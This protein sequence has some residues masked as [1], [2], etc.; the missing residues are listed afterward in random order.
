MTVGDIRL[1]H[2]TPADAELLLRWANDP[3]VRAASFESSPIE[4][5]THVRWLQDRL[6]EGTAFYIAIF[7]T[8]PVGYAR[9]ERR[10]GDSGEIAASVDAAWRGQGLGA[11]LIAAAAARA[12]VELRL[13]DIV[14]RV[15]TDNA[16]SVGAFRSAGF[17]EAGGAS[18]GVE[19][20]VWRPSLPHSRPH[21]TPED[22]EL[23]AWIVRSGRLAH[24]PHADAL[25]LEWSAA[26]GV[27]GAAAVASGL[28]AL[29]LALVALGVGPGDEVVVPAYSCVALLNAP[30]SLGAVP[31]F[32][33]VL[34]D[35]W[36]IDVEDA[37]RRISS[38]TKAI[39]AVDLFGLGADI[40]GVAGLGH[41]VIEDCAHGIGGS[42]TAGPFGRG[43]TMSI[44]SFYATK[45]IGAGEG[46]IVAAHDPALLERVRSARDYG[47]RRP[48]GVNLNDKITEVAAGLALAQLR[49][50]SVTLEHRRAAAERYG[51][52]LAGL[53]DDGLLCLP[54]Q[55][56]ERIWYRYAVRLERHAAV[57]VCRRVQNSGVMIEQP[58][59]DLRESHHW[60]NDCPSTDVAFDHVVSLPLY[61]DLSHSEQDRV[62]ESLL[63]A[64]R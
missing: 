49:R 22:A 6:S 8:I 1:R 51:T 45:M 54:R 39:V 10:G 56:E 59:W 64:L 29:R 17:R 20:L 53:R 21:L 18:G 33:D 23:A 4:R 46:G 11:R 60:R 28:G 26:I 48:A 61:P 9:V 2:A 16:A 35:D 12:A 13:V 40:A 5:E 42:T 3:A 44:A 30:L 62:V 7:G 52:L 37:A 36:S 57:E 15:K 34:L 24:G 14:A 63:A 27:T 25:E 41:P 32:A 19:T 31:V 43:G 58:V 47:D 50:L 38:R 55:S